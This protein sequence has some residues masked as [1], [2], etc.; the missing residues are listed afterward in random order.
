MR[1][2][3][4]FLT[5]LLSVL[6]VA[7]QQSNVSAS[8]STSAPT[9]TASTA[10]PTPPLAAESSHPTD[11]VQKIFGRACSAL[12]A[13]PDVRWQ[14]TGSTPKPIKGLIEVMGQDRAHFVLQAEETQEVIVIVPEIYFQR[15]GAWQKQTA[16]GAEAQQ[17][18][19]A[20]AED[21]HQLIELPVCFSSE[22]KQPNALP[23]I[24]DFRFKNLKLQ[25]S[26]AQEL[27]GT[28]V[29]FYTLS[30]TV[31]RD[32]GEVPCT[33]KYWL[34]EATDLPHQFESH[35]QTLQGET[36]MSAD[37]SYGDLD[38]QAPIP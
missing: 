6:L 25:T 4:L 9:R 20:E 26:E 30:A 18:A 38:I 29:H 16:T 8:A 7:C 3:F 14:F 33:L 24:L 10:V 35:C 37:Y 28:P 17:Q 27:K 23:P 36:Q 15:D 1:H 19:Q 22:D 34:D 31:T 12:A 13:Q 5:L 21:G 11:D 2:L 32:E